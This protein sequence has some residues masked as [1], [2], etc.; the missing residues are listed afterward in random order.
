MPDAAPR[1]ERPP[2][3]FDPAAALALLAGA[4]LV[5]CLPVLPA[6]PLDLL[7]GVVALS[8]LWRWPRLRLV[9]FALAG[10]AWTAWRADLALAERLPRELEGRDLDVSGQVRDLPD[11]QDDAVRFDL[12]VES[13]TLDG[14]AIPLNGTLRL[15]WYRT[16]PPAACSRWQLRVRLKR[17]RALLNPGGFD[18]ERHALQQ[19]IVAT[20]YVREEGPNRLL[21]TSGVCIDGLRQ[22]IATAI[23]ARLGDSPESHLLRALA[24]GDQGGIGEHE[25]Q[26]LRA[27]GVGHLIAISGLHV[28]LLAGLGVL[29]VR[30]VWK[31]FPRLVLRWPAPVIEGLGGL[32]TATAY[33]A[34]AGFGV[35]T[36]RTLLMIGTV[37]LATLARRAPSPAQGLALAGGVIIVADPLAVLAPGFWLSFIGVAWLMLC[38]GAESGRWWR[39]LVI[40][41][42][43]M[44]LGLLPLGVWFF[45]QS[46]LVGPLANLVAVPFV[47][48][49]VVPLTLLGS[50]LLV[51][52]PVAGGAILQL[53]AWA[54]QTQWALLEWFAG[55]P[56]AQW[57]LP[58]PSL[59]AFVLAMLGAFWLLLPRGVPGRALAALLFL[60]LL[61]P[62]RPPLAE[63]AFDLLVVDVGQGLS[64]LAHTADHALLFDA[65]ARYPSGFDLGEAAVVPSLHAL[66][67]TRLDRLVVSHGDNDHA[68]GARAVAAA[69]MPEVTESSVPERLPIAA[70]TCRAGESWVWNEVRFRVVSPPADAVR[71]DNDGSCVVLIEGRHAR[72]LFPGDV[73]ARIEPEIAA[74]VGD[75]T[76]PLVLVVPHHGSRTSSSEGLLEALHP[77]IALVSAGYRSRFGHPHPDVLRRYAAQGIPVLNT[78]ETG[79]IELHLQS[80]EPIVPERLCRRDRRAYWREP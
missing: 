4:V 45:G 70:A 47:S 44:S 37:A 64:V 52:L 41:Q 79:C 26:V 77:A 56:G 15:S 50:L 23:G 19:G 20:G 63:G 36:T 43:A 1:P 49:V 7:L 69:F 53:A 75:S 12:A 59:T 40:A 67:V 32:V 71:R 8:A 55:W 10:F 3:R 58:E 29:L 31:S 28:G 35:P 80:S 14:Q 72:A 74:A 68:G 76:L 51:T 46:S 5:Q 17:P 39:D 38:L 27:T 21:D 2:L 30:R 22:R 62:A 11:A 65:G 6:R 13:A 54:M 9:A 25:W 60:P 78:A 66:G 16:T 61:W 42:G 33:S 73:S 48:F 57:F 34:L 18:F 24:V